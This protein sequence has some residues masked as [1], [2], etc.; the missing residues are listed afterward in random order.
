[1]FIFY[2]R[3]RQKNFSSAY[4]LE[5]SNSY[6]SY[7][8]S[9]VVVFEAFS[10]PNLGRSS[11]FANP[12]FFA[13]GRF[14]LVTEEKKR[15]FQTKFL[16]DGLQWE[17]HS[18]SDDPIQDRLEL[19]AGTYPIYTSYFF[20]AG[21]RVPFDPL[22]VDFLHRTSLHIGHLS[23]NAVRIILSVAEINRRFGME[24]DF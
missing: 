10:F 14:A 5:V 23:P 4:L 2:I 13:M 6:S 21:L 17:E 24:L 11:S 19:A 15:Q 3:F 22:L 1:M 20:Q 18:G 9:S 8:A 12:N 7:F 16:P